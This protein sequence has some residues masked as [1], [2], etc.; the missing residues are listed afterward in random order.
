MVSWF[1]IAAHGCRCR[2]SLRCTWKCTIPFECKRVASGA[3]TFK[4]VQWVV[5]HSNTLLC[6]LPTTRRAGISGECA[7]EGPVEK[8]GACTSEGARRPRKPASGGVGN[9]AEKHT[10]R[11][12]G[13]RATYQARVAVRRLLR[14]HKHAPALGHRPL[15]ASGKGEWLTSKMITSPDTPFKDCGAGGSAE[16]LNNAY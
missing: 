8:D 15:H 4:V 3:R 2:G 16:G 1:K 11:P 5:T 12:R 14:R 10:Y 6:I 7:I 13:S 9:A